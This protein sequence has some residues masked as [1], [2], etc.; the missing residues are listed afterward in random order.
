VTG[1]QIR[2]G[3]LHVVSS[4]R[5]RNGEDVIFDIR[6][7]VVGIKQRERKGVKPEKPK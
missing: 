7:E 6:Q 5:G 3:Q 1:H 2:G 4:V